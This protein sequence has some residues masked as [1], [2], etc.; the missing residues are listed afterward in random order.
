[1]AALPRCSRVS[2]GKLPTFQVSAY[3]VIEIAPVPSAVRLR[4]FLSTDV[5]IDMEGMPSQHSESQLFGPVLLVTYS[6]RLARCICDPKHVLSLSQ[7][8]RLG[9]NPNPGP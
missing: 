3:V 5:V 8:H 9:R 7:S 1:M 6:I 2:L 4:L